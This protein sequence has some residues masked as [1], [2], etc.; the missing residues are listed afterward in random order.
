[1]ECLPFL[2]LRQWAGFFFVRQKTSEFPKL[3]ELLGPLPHLR[4]IAELWDTQRVLKLAI[5]DFN[6]PY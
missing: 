6:F 3:S 1:M 2:P 4:N 5:S